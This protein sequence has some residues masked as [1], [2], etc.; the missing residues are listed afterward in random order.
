MLFQCFQWQFGFGGYQLFLYQLYQ[1]SAIDHAHVSKAAGFN[2]FD[3]KF[4]EQN[5]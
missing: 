3:F 4:K 2:E 1:L 5:S